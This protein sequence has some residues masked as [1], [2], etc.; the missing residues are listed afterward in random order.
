MTQHDENQATAIADAL[1]AP[2]SAERETTRIQRE[3]HRAA[4]AVLHKTKRRIAALALA[5]GALGVVVAHYTGQGWMQG[6][7][8]GALVGAG[9]G[10]MSLP[11]WPS[12]EKMN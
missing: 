4:T 10:W 2:R 6:Y 11:L 8:Y 1:Q 12:A 3:Q 5:S 9:L 7:L